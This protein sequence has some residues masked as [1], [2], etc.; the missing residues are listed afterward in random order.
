M[1]IFKKEKAVAKAAYEYLDT[2]EHCVLA[3]ER[4]V[5]GYI[6][7]ELKSPDDA[8]VEVNK[9]EAKADAQ[10]RSIADT[11]FL[12]AYLPLMRGDIYGLFDSIDHV[13]NA[14][15][16]TATLVFSE[17]P[18]IPDEF[19]DA[20]AEV[21]RNSFRVIEP[22]K[23]VVKAFFKPKGKIDSIREGAREIGLL[24]STVDELELA[25]TIRIFEST[26]L[27]LCSK[28]H[29][30]KLLDRIVRIS[31]K[32]EDTSDELVLIAMKSVA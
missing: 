31:D 20:F 1:K 10:R 13:P 7:D 14:A 19:R 24:E 12:G 28:A 3:A 11:L 9:L 23:K 16:A 22:L 18:S 25:L 27:D 5:L 21:A 32:A 6:D 15:E 29:L 8:I 2:A 26:D 4:F 30:R 17:K